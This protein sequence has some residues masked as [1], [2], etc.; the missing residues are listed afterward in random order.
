M[1]ELKEEAKRHHEAK[2]HKYGCGGKAR[3][4]YAH[5][6]HVR[7]PDEKED[8]ALIKK[9]VKSSCLKHPAHKAGGGPIGGGASPV[10]GR[11]R[12]AGAGKGKTNI[13]IN[14]GKP[15]GGP[16]MMPPP[17][18]GAGPAMPPPVAARPPMPVIPPRAPMGAPPGAGPMKHGGA[19]HKRKH[20][21]HHHRGHHHSNRDVR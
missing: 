1:K 4:G 18:L 8:E 13:G 21:G 16:G 20:Q 17:G 19:A 5:G 9:E 14:I 12:R 3:G 15:D 6:G 10:L 2:L 7:H 11:H